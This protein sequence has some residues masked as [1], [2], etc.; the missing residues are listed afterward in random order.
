MLRIKH[1]GS[2]CSSNIG[3]LVVCAVVFGFVVAC[4]GPDNSVELPAVSESTTSTTGGVTITSRLSTTEATLAV[5]AESAVEVWETLLA[6][7]A[8]GVEAERLEPFAVGDVVERLTAIFSGQ[9]RGVTSYAV[10]VTNSDGSVSIDDCMIL[11]SPISTSRSVW[12]SGVVKPVGDG[13]VVESAVPESLVGCVPAELATEIID[14]YLAH[15]NARSV[16]SDPPNA[17]APELRATTTGPQLELYLRLLPD[18]AQDGMRLVDDPAVMHPEII[19]VLDSDRVVIGD[20]QIAN[21]DRGVYDV[22]TGERTDLIPPI[23]EGQLDAIE[24]TMVLEDGVWKVDTVAGSRGLAC[25]FAPTRH[26][27]PIIPL[28]EG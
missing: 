23:A 2:R 1:A 5:D 20:C 25:D 8:Q 26:G 18:L 9:L 16:F 13:W 21:Q 3:R 19:N 11:T 24:T 14:G 6:T 22:D 27:L 28:G 12:F 10:A 15:F 4:S 17:D 7:A